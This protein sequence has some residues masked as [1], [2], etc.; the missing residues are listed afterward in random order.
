MAVTATIEGVDELV[1][2]F[3]SLPASVVSGVKTT[4]L[5]NFIIA[6]V[7]DTGYLTRQIKPGPK[8]MWSVNVYGERKV[9]TVY[10]PTGFIR[11]R[12]VD[13]VAVLND[14]FNR[15]NFANRP[16]GEWAAAVETMMRNAAQRCAEIVSRGAP[17]DTGEL[18]DSIIPAFPGDSALS[19]ES[20]GGT[21]NIDDFLEAP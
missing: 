19:G 9:L 20:N 11:I 5:K 17:V 14:E 10:A 7:W 6:T 15:A 3:S 18:K 12:R 21:L 4:D 16:M 13:Y 2:S 1:R 8:T